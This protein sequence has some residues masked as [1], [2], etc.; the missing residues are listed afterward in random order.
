MKNH[1]LGRATCVA[2][3]TLLATGGW[4]ADYAGYTAKSDKPL[5][6][7]VRLGPDEKSPTMLVVLDESKGTGKGYDTAVADLNL[8]GKLDDDKVTTTTSQNKETRFRIEAVAPFRD[9]DS[10]AQY[11]LEMILNKG[12]KGQPPDA[13]IVGKV[14][15]KRGAESWYYLFLNRKTKPDPKD[16]DLQLLSF[17]TPITLETNATQKSLAAE[18]DKPAGPGIAASATMKDADGQVLRVARVDKREIKP[19]LTLKSSAGKTIE[20]KD[21][22]YG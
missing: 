20:D 6:Y 19:H 22:E 11:G 21:M 17:G 15:M 9:V 18:K 7:S 2:L 10:K 1:L 16:A 4:A 12:A 8:N 3:L 14:E 5:R 13:F